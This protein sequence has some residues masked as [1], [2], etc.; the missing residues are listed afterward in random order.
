[1][2]LLEGL[3]IFLCSSN[4]PPQFAYFDVYV[5]NKKMARELRLDREEEKY[6]AASNREIWR[7]SQV[8]T[9]MG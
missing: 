9:R 2:S 7:M 6:E 8:H 5:Q 4:D 3:H 1:L